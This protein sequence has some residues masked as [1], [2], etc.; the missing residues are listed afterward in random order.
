MRVLAPLLMLLPACND[1]GGVAV[2][3]PETDTSDTASAEATVDVATTGV[4]SC[5]DPSLREQQ[6][7]DDQLAPGE[8]PKPA[9]FWGGGIL[10][11]VLTPEVV[12]AVN[13]E[14]EPFMER[15]A[16]STLAASVAEVHDLGQENRDQTA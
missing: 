11:G 8:P 10:T 9:W 6:T 3:R 12:G 16:S 7:F 4:I 2:L 15:H 13:R 5:A 14:I 1:G